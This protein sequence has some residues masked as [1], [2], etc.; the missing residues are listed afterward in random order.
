MVF[1]KKWSLDKKDT[2]D[3][4]TQ[5]GTP[6]KNTTEL[7]SYRLF[8]FYVRAKVPEALL[9]HRACLTVWELYVT[10]YLSTLFSQV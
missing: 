8:L 10:S 9:Q 6:K 4:A 2:A 5:G 7:T 3:S 1:G